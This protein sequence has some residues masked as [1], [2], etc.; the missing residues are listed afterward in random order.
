MWRHTFVITYMQPRKKVALLRF[1]WKLPLR[2]RTWTQVL[3]LD[4]R[5][6]K[7]VCVC[8]FLMSE[9]S[10]PLLFLYKDP[11]SDTPFKGTT[12][13]KSLLRLP[14][15]PGNRIMNRAK[16]QSAEISQTTSKCHRSFISCCG[17]LTCVCHLKKNNHDAVFHCV[18][19]TRVGLHDLLT[20]RPCQLL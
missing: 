13:H 16:E 7:C 19:G 1:V 8:V 6:C 20:P 11:L 3:P 10:L 5:L 9:P 18:K 2:Q 14:G 15:T 4:V 12:L 17:G